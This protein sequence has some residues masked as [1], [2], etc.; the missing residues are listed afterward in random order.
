MPLISPK[1]LFY[2]SAFAILFACVGCSGSSTVSSDKL[3][4]LGQEK[5]D[6][7]LY[8]EA[9]DLFTELAEI[10]PTATNHALIGDCFWKRRKLEEADVHYRKALE[11][12]PKH[13]GAN[14]ALGRDA[15]LLKRY[16]DAVPYLNEANELCA[17]SVLHAQNL[18]FRVEASLELG[19]IAEAEVDMATLTSEYPENANT[20]EAGVLV[21]TKNG[22]EA[23]AAEYQ[24]KLNALANGQSQ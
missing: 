11:L 3:F 21:A 23:L 2:V 1:R 22:D 13:C 4:K 10:S 5:L 12:D 9:I 15:V 14:H 17:G 19:K 18:R 6:A 24:A 20:Y 8:D 16:Q 7:K